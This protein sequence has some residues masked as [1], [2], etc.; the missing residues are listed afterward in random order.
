[1]PISSYAHDEF[2]STNFIFDY[3]KNW[4]QERGMEAM[5]GARGIVETMGMAET[6]GTEGREDIEEG[7]EGTEGNDGE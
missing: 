3:C 4:L 1:M 2:C 7:T 5:D 6:I